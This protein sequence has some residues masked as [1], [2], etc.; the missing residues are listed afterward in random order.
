MQL[1]NDPY[2]YPAASKT[3]RDLRLTKPEVECLIPRYYST[4]AYSPWDAE[5]SWFSCPHARHAAYRRMAR[6]LESAAHLNHHWSRHVQWTGL[7]RHVRHLQSTDGNGQQFLGIRFLSKWCFSG[8]RALNKMWK[9]IVPR[10]AVEERALVLYCLFFHPH[11]VKEK[12]PLF[13]SLA[14]VR[15]YLRCLIRNGILRV[16]MVTNKEAATINSAP[17]KRVRPPPK[18]R[19]RLE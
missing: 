4:C 14:R 1:G 13:T 11:Q 18:K 16:A 17:A 2:A 12:S 15:A 10:S 5:E 8:P 19:Q 7:L 3:I 9:H 6:N